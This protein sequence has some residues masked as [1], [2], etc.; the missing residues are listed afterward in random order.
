M[1]KKV[2]EH[3]FFERFAELVALRNSQSHL[4]F[5]CR[6]CRLLLRPT[7]AHSSA[8]PSSSFSCPFLLYIFRFL[9]HRSTLL[10]CFV[11]LFVLLLLLFALLRVFLSIVRLLCFLLSIV[12]LL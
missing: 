9:D 10:I 3:F 8:Y 6:R 11:F 7:A 1:L 12:R 5:H 2:Y 4:A